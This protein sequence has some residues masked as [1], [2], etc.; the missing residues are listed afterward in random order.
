MHEEGIPAFLM[1]AAFAAIT[2][3]VIVGINIMVF[4]MLSPK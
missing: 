2:I 3:G 4:A 1:I